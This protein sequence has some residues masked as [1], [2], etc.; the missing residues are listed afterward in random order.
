MPAPTLFPSHPKLDTETWSAGVRPLDGDP[1]II[2]SHQGA[3]HQ[4][5]YLLLQ[6]LLKQSQKI[7]VMFHCISHPATGIGHVLKGAEGPQEASAARWNLDRQP[8]GSSCTTL[9]LVMTPVL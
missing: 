6:P 8:T 7:K 1:N 4:D 5:T 3:P 2:P 9:A